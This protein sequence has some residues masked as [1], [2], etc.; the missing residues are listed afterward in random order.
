MSTNSGNS[1]RVMTFC[2]TCR[3]Q[4]C[5]VPAQVFLC[6]RVSGRL[7]VVLPNVLV[8]LYP[9]GALDAAVPFLRIQWAV[10]VGPSHPPALPP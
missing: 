2:D 8:K 5:I 10:Q 4:H 9:K 3:Q 7:H 6:V 1:A